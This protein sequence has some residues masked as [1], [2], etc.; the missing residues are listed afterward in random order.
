MKTIPFERLMDGYS[1][2]ERKAIED[3]ADAAF[4]LTEARI[5]AGLSLHEAA[6]ALGISAEE[7]NACECGVG[8]IARIRNLKRSL[9][10][11]VHKQK[12]PVH[13]RIK[14]S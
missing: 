2:E 14:V 11:A 4:Q 13:L 10:S 7:L 8:D 5:D 12:P 3:Q 1:P 6:Q 9:V